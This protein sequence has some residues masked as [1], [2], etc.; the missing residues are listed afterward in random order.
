MLKK[1]KI[2]KTHHLA[3]TEP[4]LDLGAIPPPP[5]NFFFLNITIYMGT[6][7]SNFILENYIFAPLKIT[8]I[9]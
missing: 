8:L 7:F 9:L 6:N 4:W 3:W 5:Q 2:H 1:K